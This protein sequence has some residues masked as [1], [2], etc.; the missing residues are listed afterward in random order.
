[1]RTLLAILLTATLAFIAGTY[2]PW[3][4]IAIVAFLVALL[5]RQSPGMG[6]LSGFLGIFLCWGIVALWIDIRN[7]H[8]L[9]QRIAGLMKLGDSSVLI[10]L[11]T[12][13]VGGLVGGFAAMAGSALL[14]SRKKRRQV[15]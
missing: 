8:I 10:L 3:W 9:S 11:V 2:L 1:M 12:A 4:S 15:R 13:L 6:F 5:L 14:P 7:Q